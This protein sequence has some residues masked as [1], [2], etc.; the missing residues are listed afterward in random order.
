M[1]CVAAAHATWIPKEAETATASFLCFSRRDHSPTLAPSD[2]GRASLAP[3]SLGGS[4]GS[5]KS[6][7]DQ[8]TWSE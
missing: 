5:P 4:G 7:A 1:A 8:A 6:G 3:S 2:A